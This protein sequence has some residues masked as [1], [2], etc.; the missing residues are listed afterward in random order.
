MHMR[1]VGQIKAQFLWD[2]VYLFMTMLHATLKCS[3]CFFTYYFSGKI[4]KVTIIRLLFDK[5]SHSGDVVLMDSWR[6]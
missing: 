3:L 1:I 6:Y 5:L 4:L 2:F